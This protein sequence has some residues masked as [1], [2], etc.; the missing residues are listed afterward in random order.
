MYKAIQAIVMEEGPY[1]I[2]YS[3]LTQIAARKVVQGLEIPPMWYYTELFSV[4]KT[5]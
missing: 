4:S 3:P 1:A 5:G 2:L